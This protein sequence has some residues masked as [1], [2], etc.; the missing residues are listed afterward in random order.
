MTFLKPHRTLITLSAAFVF[1]IVLLACASQSSA[2]PVVTAFVPAASALPA[3][4]QPPESIDTAVPA[5]APNTIQIQIRG[6]EVSVIEPENAPGLKFKLGTEIVLL[7]DSDR[8]DEL[9]VHGYD[10]LEDVG[11]GIPLSR[12]SFVANIPGQFEIELENSRLRLANIT[13]S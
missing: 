3:E 6:S 1:G 4:T 5:A 8:A 9:H 2:N 12:H 13:V 10:L 11:P 7:I